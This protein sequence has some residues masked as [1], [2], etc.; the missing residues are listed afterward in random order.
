MLLES[1][2]CCYWTLILHGP[3]GMLVNW[4][5]ETLVT[6]FWKTMP[7]SF[8]GKPSHY[9][10]VTMWNQPV[11]PMMVVCSSHTFIIL[12]PHHPQGLNWPLECQDRFSH[13]SP[14]EARTVVPLHCLGIHTLEVEH[15]LLLDI[16][17]TIQ[18]IR[19][20]PFSLASEILDNSL[21]QHYLQGHQS[22]FSLFS[23]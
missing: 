11:C 17:N 7:W 4:C 23:C 15:L 19:W 18:C 3:A 5:S 13:P 21:G 16:E 6:R 1:I 20:Y 2:M 22:A 10:N 8:L 9:H 12:S 14:N